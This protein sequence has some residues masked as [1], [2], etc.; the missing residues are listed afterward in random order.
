[1]SRRRRT[2]SGGTSGGSLPASA[3]LVHTGNGGRGSRDASK[4]ALTPGDDHLSEDSVEKENSVEVDDDG[5]RDPD[6]DNAADLPPLGTA[7]I[8]HQV[9][10]ELSGLRAQ[11]AVLTA[12]A[13]VLRQQL[14]DEAR[15]R[16]EREE[17]TK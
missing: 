17:E 1:A 2:N 13:E 10:S 16:E 15:E 14:E 4:S 6:L 5:S 12:E 11:N 7:D 3:T 9:L 8:A